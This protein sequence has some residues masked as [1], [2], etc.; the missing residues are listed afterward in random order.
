MSDE[1]TVVAEPSDHPVSQQLISEFFAEIVALYPTLDPG[2]IP[3]AHPVEVSAPHG[4]W[5]VAYLGGDAIGCGGVKRFD[6]LAA[7]VKRVYVR[8]VARGRGVARA[9]MS[10]LEAD[11]RELGYRR[12]RLDTGM[13]QP[14]ALRLYLGLGYVEIADY[15]GNPFASYWMEKAL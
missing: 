1:I 13:Q 9:L 11:A 4:A 7:E 6:E 15:N 12:L 8:P 3:S 14:D 5:R 2:L 10:A